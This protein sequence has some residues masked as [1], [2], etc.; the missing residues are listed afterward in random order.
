MHVTCVSALRDYFGLEKRPAKVHEP[1]QLLGLIED[2]LAQAIGTDVEGVVPAKT[3]FGFPVCDWKPWRTPWGGLEVLVPSGFNTTVDANGDTCIYP[4]G[5]TSAAPS[6]RMPTGSYF[7]DAIIRQEPICEEHLDPAD[8]LEEFGPLSAADILWLQ[9]EVCRAAST[10]RAVLACLPGTALGDIALVPGPALKH[11]KGIRDVTEWYVSTRSR[12]NL[13]HQIFEKQCEIAIGN[14][15]RIKSATGDL[16]DVAFTCGTDFGTQTSAFCSNATFRELYLPHYKTVHDWIH[17]NTG[18]RTFKHSCGSVERF[19]PSFIDAGIDILNQVQCSA[20]GMDP[21]RLKSRYGESI[22]FWGGG[23]NT[24]KTLPFGTPAQVREE[25]LRRCE[26]FSRSG[27][28]VF[29]SIHNVQA[30]TPV[31]NVI[32]MIDAVHEFNGRKA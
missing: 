4:E 28:F 3:M 12:R 31:E 26:I 8:N 13:L 2:D 29:T 21:E 18:W 15:E 16:I 19:I 27:G 22:V 25:V 23:V 32:A 7:F 20:V 10:G 1:F 30:Q 9:K 24:Q 11:P 14:L 17:R 6:A 5:D